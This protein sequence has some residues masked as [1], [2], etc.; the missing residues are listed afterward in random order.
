M[1]P[2]P[3]GENVLLTYNVMIYTLT[4]T[5]SSFQWKTLSWCISLQ[6]SSHVQFLVPASLI[7][8]EE[9]EDYNDW[10][11][12]NECEHSLPSDNEGCGDWVGYTGY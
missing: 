2:T 10:K 4:I 11:Y 5:G 6:R 12:W 8:C 7:S 3:D 9:D 1:S